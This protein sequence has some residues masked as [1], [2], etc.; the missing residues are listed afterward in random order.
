MSYYLI[1]N[2]LSV[3][4]PLAWSFDRRIDYYKKWPALFLGTVLVGGVFIIWDVVFTRMGVWGFNPDYLVGVDIINLPLE[5]WLFFLLIPYAC[6]F[7][8]ESLNYFIPSRPLKKVTKPILMALIPVL[9]V[10]G[11]WH[12]DRWYTAVTLIS[13]SLFSCGTAQVSQKRLS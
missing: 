9:L 5:E 3:S 11:V 1:L 8:Y 13:T 2:L 4:F 6:L 10:I 7:I 12:Y